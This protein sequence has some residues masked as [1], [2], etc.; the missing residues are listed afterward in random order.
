VRI[1]NLTNFYPPCT[2]GG[3][4]LWCQE[5][6]DRLRKRG[7][8]VLILTSR[9]GRQYRARDPLWVHRDLHLEMSLAP[10]LNSVRF[11]VGRRS[12]K[13]HNLEALRSVVVAFEP[14]CILIWGM[15]NL[16]SSL[17][18]ATERLLPN[19]VAYYMGDYW[20]TLPDQEI[21]YW[22]SPAR[23][24]AA[25]VVKAPLRALAAQVMAGKLQASPPLKRVM[26]PSRFMREELARRGVCPAM[27]RI[28]YGA[29]DT[30]RYTANR[31]EDGSSAVRLLCVS[32]LTADKG[33]HTAIE[34]LAK[35]DGREAPGCYTL[36]IVGS[37]EAEYE[38]SLVA[39]ARRLGVE[40]LVKFLGAQP[41]E[42]MPRLYGNADIF[43]FTSIWPEP[44]GR[45]LIEAMASGLVVIGAAVGGASE[46]LADGENGLAYSPGDADGL[47]SQVH[48]AVSDPVLRHGLVERARAACNR[49]DVERMAVEIEDFLV[50]IVR[51]S[52][53]LADTRENG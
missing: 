45:T 52:G 48:R 23:S 18:V 42:L 17:A 8:R 7:H 20:P 5:V 32:R 16:H 44:F 13:A 36:T 30:S 9:C 35:L 34:A 27:S 2:R 53:S 19:R 14:H 1:L 10:L 51:E 11:F 47:A 31:R 41:P 6:G 24:T 37:G 38:R 15:W 12:R 46:I 50:Q 26:F 4:E 25:A 49:F 21:C 39:L 33:V 29:I 43:L 40:H 3:Y 28:V 22:N